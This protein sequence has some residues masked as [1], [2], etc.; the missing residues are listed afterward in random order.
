M[1]IGNVR[2]DAGKPIAGSAVSFGWHSDMSYRRHPPAITFLYAV[3]VPASGG[4]THF[5]SLYRLYDELDPATREAWSA[6]EVE[7][8]ARSAS[9]DRYRDRLNVHPLVRRHPD[10]GRWLVFASPA[11]TKR[12][13]GLSGTDSDRVLRRLDAAIGRPDAVHR[14]QEHD[15]LVWDNRAVLHRAT[16]HDDRERRYLWRVAINLAADPE[17]SAADGGVAGADGARLEA[18]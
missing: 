15:L 14:W 6:F 18:C 7:H 10:S 3:A 16:P 1:A 13:I 9:L 8:E 4:D 17:A 2:D 12:V 11:Y 5:S